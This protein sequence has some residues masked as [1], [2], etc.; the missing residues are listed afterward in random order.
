MCDIG[1]CEGQF[2]RQRCKALPASN[3][4]HTPI[5]KIANIFFETII[6]VKILI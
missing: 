3:Q 1:Q 5:K 4:T 2:L 6:D